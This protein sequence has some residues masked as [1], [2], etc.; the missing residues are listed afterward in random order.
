MFRQPA[1]A[2]ISLSVCAGWSEPL[3]VAHTALEISCQGPYT[4]LVKARGFWLLS[5]G[6]CPAKTWSFYWMWTANFST[7]KKKE[8]KKCVWCVCVFL[9]G[10]WMVHWPFKCDFIVFKVFVLFLSNE[11][12]HCFIGGCHD[13]TCSGH[14]C[15]VMCGYNIVNDMMLS[16]E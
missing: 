1:K 14:K 6:S 3:L 7:W 9:P 8:W 12:L 15:Y 2:L 5:V 13:V 11:N 10:L 4:S 16:A